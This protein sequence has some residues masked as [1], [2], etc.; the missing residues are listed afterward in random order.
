MLMR[1]LYKDDMSMMLIMGIFRSSREGSSRKSSR[2]ERCW[3][4]RG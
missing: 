2:V 3:I 4:G 1:M